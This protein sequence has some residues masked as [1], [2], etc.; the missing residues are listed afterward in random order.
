MCS[1]CS[2]VRLFDGFILVHVQ[3]RHHLTIPVHQLIGD[4]QGRTQDFQ[5]GGEGL[6]RDMIIDH[7]VLPL[8]LT[9]QGNSESVKK[10]RSFW[11]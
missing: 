7:L 3:I 10:M 4:N 6:I 8:V 1:V 9:L 5:G 11:K 2:G